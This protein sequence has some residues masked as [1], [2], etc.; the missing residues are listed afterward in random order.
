MCGCLDEMARFMSCLILDV[1][2][3]NSLLGSI[4]AIDAVDDLLLC[5]TVAVGRNDFDFIG[6]TFHNMSCCCVFDGHKDEWNVRNALDGHIII[7]A[8]MVSNN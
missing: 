2:A 4:I 7:R 1:S 8:M 6:T 5:S 3:Y